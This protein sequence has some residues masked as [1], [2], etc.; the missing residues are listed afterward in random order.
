MNQCENCKNAIWEV[1]EYHSARECGLA[2][3]NGARIIDCKKIDEISDDVFEEWQNNR[4][5]HD[6]EEQEE[7]E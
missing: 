6:C 2:G 1:I 7:W 3:G 5:I 4:D